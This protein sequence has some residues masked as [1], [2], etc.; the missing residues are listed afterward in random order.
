MNIK[1]AIIT[2]MAV[3][4]ILAL[5]AFPTFAAKDTDH[6]KA[7]LWH[8]G[9]N[10]ASCTGPFT[11][12]GSGNVQVWTSDKNGA[13]KL[14][15]TLKRGGLPNT[16]YDVDIRCVGKIGTLKTDADGNGEAEIAWPS[17][18]TSPFFVDVSVFGGGGGAGGYGDTF[19]AGP[20][21]LD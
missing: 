13:F 3:S 11:G 7:E 12:T 20:F 8:V 1:K 21:S 16:T 15:V 6:G 9:L 14:E 2:G 5:A 10:P 4:G 17:T 18:P 19:I